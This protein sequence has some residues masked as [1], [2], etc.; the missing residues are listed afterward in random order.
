MYLEIYSSGG[1]RPVTLIRILILEAGNQIKANKIE[2]FAE[3]ICHCK[4]FF[5][6]LKDLS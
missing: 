4:K 2:I 6:F 3:G 1:I 5:G